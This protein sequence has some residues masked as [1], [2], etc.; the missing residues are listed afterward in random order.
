MTCPTRP[1]LLTTIAQLDQALDNHEQWHKGIVRALIAHLPPEPADLAPDAHRRCRLGQWYDSD[2]TRTLRD[3]PAF[4]ALGKAHEQMHRTAT[5]LLQH[6]GN[7]LPIHPEEIDAF[8][9]VRDR[10][11]LELQSLRQELAEALANRDPLTGAR[12]RVSMLSDLREQHS[13]VQRGAQPC[14]IAIIDLDLFK[15]INDHYGHLTGDTVL[16]STVQCLESLIRPYDRIYR[17][18]GEEFLL[19]MPNTSVDAAIQLAERLRAAV[20]AI[21]V[22]NSDGAIL[23]VS[24]SFGVAALDKVRSVEDSIDKA[25]KAMYL[26]KRRGRDRVEAEE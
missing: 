20:A 1:Q 2:E 12:N 7:R 4:L 22:K 23:R 26:A 8:G 16:A 11:K 15:K 3:H 9:D 18:G 10:L 25:D 19:C 24:A 6:A 21:E 17:Y 14:A 5:K 13:L